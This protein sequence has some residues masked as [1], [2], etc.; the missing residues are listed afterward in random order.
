MKI[1]VSTDHAG[2]EAVKQLVSFLEEIGHE[3]VDYG[4]KEYV[5]TDDYP[6]FI[7]PCA[8]AVAS[9]ECEVGIIFGMS[10]QGEAMVANRVKGVRCGLYYGKQTA[11]SDQSEDPYEILRLNR[12]HNNANMLSIGARFVKFDEIKEAV[13]IW[14]ETPFSEDERHQRRI[15]KIDEV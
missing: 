9:G 5:A 3:V 4:P 15:N 10:G 2:F 13:R 11:H 6:D 1:A 12:Q 7:R 14:L 8:E